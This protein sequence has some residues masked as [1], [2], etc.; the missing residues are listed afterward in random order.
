MTAHTLP[1]R[2][3]SSPRAKPKKQLCT[4]ARRRKFARLMRVLM[5]KC[6]LVWKGK[7][8]TERFFSRARESKMSRTISAPAT[9]L[10]SCW[11]RNIRTRAAIEQWE[12]A[13]ALDANDGNTQSNLAWVLATAPNASLRNG[14]RAVELAERAL[15]LAGGVSPILHR[16]LA[17]AYAEA[18]RFEDAIATAERGRALAEREGNRELADE[19][20]AVLPIPTAPTLPRRQP[21][22]AGRLITR[23]ACEQEL[24]GRAPRARVAQPSWLWGQRASCP[25]IR[26]IRRSVK[27]GPGQSLHRITLQLW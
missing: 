27:R 7:H 25:L 4:R 15:K 11:C 12:S 1:S 2:P 16:T 22:T 20:T 21:A 24:E 6:R 14:I 8:S 23:S 17:A 10:V 13:L 5:G 18:G 3:R 26:A 9:H 19:F